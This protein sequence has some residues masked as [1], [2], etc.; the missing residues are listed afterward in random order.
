MATSLKKN[1][2]LKEEKKNRKLMCLA[3]NRCMLVMS[4]DASLELR[5]VKAEYL[6][7]QYR[8]ELQALEINVVCLES[9][10]RST[11][12]YGKWLSRQFSHT[13]N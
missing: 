4:F 3:A 12:V 2:T 7:T 13:L 6:C 10:H 8:E 5:E 11:F 9:T 1:R